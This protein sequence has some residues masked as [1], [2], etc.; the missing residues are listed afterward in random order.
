VCGERVWYCR[1]LEGNAYDTDTWD[2]CASA[3]NGLPGEMHA[4]LLFNGDNSE[5]AAP[6]RW[7]QMRVRRRMNSSIGLRGARR[8]AGGRARGTNQQCSLMQHPLPVLTVLVWHH[9]PSAQADGLEEGY[10]AV[11]ADLIARVHDHY[12]LA[13]ERLSNKEGV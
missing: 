3:F 12:S 13:R 9:H 6:N 2:V 10:I 11:P 4:V 1:D 7:L 8:R 5:T